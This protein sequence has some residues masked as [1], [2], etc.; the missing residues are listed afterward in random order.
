MIQ[1]F[2][3]NIGGAAGGG[4]VMNTDDPVPSD[5]GGLEAGTDINGMSPC[6]VLKLILYPYAYPAFTSFYIANQSTVLE[7]GDKVT[8]GVRTFKWSTTND[9]N[10]QENSISIKDLTQN[11]TLGSNLAN[12]GQEDLDIGSDIVYTSPATHTWQISGVN[13]KNETFTRNFSVRWYY[14]VYWGSSPNDTLTED[15]IKA[16]PN[17]QLKPNATGDYNFSNDNG[18]E[19]Y[20]YVVYPDSWG[21]ISSWV[22]TDT[23]FGVDYTNAGTVDVTNDFGVTVTYRLLRTTYK[24]TAPLNSHI[25]Q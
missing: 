7:V 1:F 23:G 20:Y 17:S 21:D 9:E 10:I 24:Q 15:E 22:D 18:D 13:T 25:D 16:L 4:C 14:R 19:L 6:D 8:G 12:D 2:R 3:K 5:H 11:T